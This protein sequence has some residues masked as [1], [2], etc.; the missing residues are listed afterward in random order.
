[1]PYGCNDKIDSIVNPSIPRCS[2]VNVMRIFNENT[3]RKRGHG[4][5]H[6]TSPQKHDVSLDSLLPFLQKPLGLYNIRTKLYFLPR[7]K[8]HS[9]QKTC[10]NTIYPSSALY[11]LAAV[12]L[13]ISNHRLFKPVVE[14]AD[15]EE[16]KNFS[17]LQF[18]NKGLDAINLANILHHKSVKEKTPPYFQ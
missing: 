1:M 17:S 12:V 3:R 16:P 11:R 4:H 14:H 2:D 18:A 13:D 9:L 8:L 10:L 15:K 7:A 6:Y 5:R